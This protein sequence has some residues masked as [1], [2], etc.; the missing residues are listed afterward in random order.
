LKINR[1]GG[2]RMHIKG[3]GVIIFLIISPGILITKTQVPIIN[4][5]PKILGTVKSGGIDTCSSLH[6]PPF[7][8]FSENYQV[9]YE[10]SLAEC[11]YQTP[12]WIKAIVIAWYNYDTLSPSRE[13]DI[14]LWLWPSGTSPDCN[15]PYFIYQTTTGNLPPGAWLVQYD[16]HEL[17]IPF[18][19][20]MWFGHYEMVNGPPTSMLDLERDIHQ[21]Y[22]ETFVNLYSSNCI[23]WDTDYDHYQFLVLDT[24]PPVNFKERA[25][26][27]DSTIN[28]S[29]SCSGMISFTLPTSSSVTLRIFDVKGSLVD[30]IRGVYT[31]GEHSLN[32]KKALTGVYFLNLRV[33]SYTETKEFLIIK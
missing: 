2:W 28:L 12:R 31:A 25:I 20:K 16:I 11:E 18:T 15:S 22:D 24:L 9:E 32:W 26:I 19:F 4:I 5:K 3:V 13:K 7:Y 30:E 1:K 33:G 14:I 17:S 21:D 29:I 27:G 23:N 10:A 6:E 8:Y